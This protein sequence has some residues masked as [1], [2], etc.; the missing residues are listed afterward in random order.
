MC[1]Y[2]YMGSDNELPLIE[3]KKDEE[4]PICV[5]RL[6][7]GNDDDDF[8]ERQLT[9]KYKYYVGAWQGCGC[10]FR[11]DFVEADK[12]MNEM[13]EQEK[14]ELEMACNGSIDDIVYGHSKKGK[15]SVEALFDYICANV[16]GGECELLHF[17]SGCNR[18]ERHDVI[19][20]KSFVL[21]DTF[22]FPERQYITVYK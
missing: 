8:A 21:G 2:L 19:D 1:W 16:E 17:G 9:K 11:F 5:R 10:N 7:C 15:R 14:Q 6:S 12:F 3:W 20:L 22:K 4:L 18:I 13:S